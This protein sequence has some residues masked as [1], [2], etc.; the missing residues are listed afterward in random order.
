MYQIVSAKICINADSAQKCRKLRVSVAAKFASVNRI[1]TIKTNYINQFSFLNFYLTFF[2]TPF[3]FSRLSNRVN[4]RN[5]FISVQ[6]YELYRL[7]DCRALGEFL[8]EL[9]NF[10]R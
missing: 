7:S 9:S 1:M 3:N 4:F 5:I 2:T 10:S 8:F 6:R